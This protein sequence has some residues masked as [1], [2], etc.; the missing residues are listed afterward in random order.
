MAGAEPW[1]GWREALD[2]D[3]RE[4]LEVAELSEAL[5]RSCLEEQRDSLRRKHRDR[6]AVANAQH[7]SLAELD[8]EQREYLQQLEQATATSKLEEERRLERVMLEEAIDELAAIDA[9]LL[10]QHAV[11]KRLDDDLKSLVNGF[12]KQART[13]ELMPPQRPAR[14][15]RMPPPLAPSWAL[16][17]SYVSASRVTPGL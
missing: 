15:L 4:A 13:V 6:S 3:C 5:Q 10:D 7:R 14:Q 8:G 9:S 16:G 12:Q 11:W 2:D 1:R 17:Q